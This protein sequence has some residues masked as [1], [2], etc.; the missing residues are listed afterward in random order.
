MQG[1]VD[2]GEATLWHATK[3]VWLECPRLIPFEGQDGTEKTDS[4][5]RLVVMASTDTQLRLLRVTIKPTPPLDSTQ[6]ER[7]TRMSSIKFW[8]RSEGGGKKEATL[9]ETAKLRT[10]PKVPIPS[11]EIPNHQFWGTSSSG[12]MKRK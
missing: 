3:I 6:F 7:G 2:F 10:I 5:R 11:G 8:M 4:P 12:A 1:I 9:A